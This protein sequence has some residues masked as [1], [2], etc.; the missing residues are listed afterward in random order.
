MFALFVGAYF[1]SAQVVFDPATYSGTIGTNMKIVTVGSDSYLQVVLDGYSDINLDP[2]AII[3]GETVKTS[4]KYASGIADGAIDTCAVFFKISNASID[5][6][7]NSS[8]GN[9]SA[10]FKEYSKAIEKQGVVEKLTIAAQVNKGSWPSIKG[11]TLWIGKVTVEPYNQPIEHKFITLET[12]GTQARDTDNT[13]KQ[14]TGWRNTPGLDTATAFHYDWTECTF[15]N[16]NGII[17][18]GSDSSIRINSYGVSSKPSDWPNP[19]GGMQLLMTPTASYMGSWDT[20][21]FS[22]IDVKGYNVENIA[23]GFAKRGNGFKSLDTAGINIEYKIDGGTWEQ[24]DTTVLPHGLVAD[25]WE[26]VKIPL[27]VTGDKI[28]LRIASF[29]NQAFID[30]IAVIGTRL[31]DEPLAIENIVVGKVDSAGDFTGSVQLEWDNDSIYVI[32]NI[33]DDSIVPG[34]PEYQVDNIEVYFDMDNSKNIHWPRNGGWM[35]SDPT[36]DTNDYQFRL[37]PDSAFAK[38]NSKFKGARQVYTKTADGYQFELNIALDSL[39]N[40]FKP[41]PYQRI[42]FDVLVSDNDAVASDA[43]RNQI[44]LVSPTDKPF[45]DPSLWG[46]LEFVEGG[47][48]NLLIDNQAPTTAPV[49]TASLATEFDSTINLSWTAATDNIAILK[50]IVKSNGKDTVTVYPSAAGAAVTS[51]LSDQNPGIYIISVTAVDNSGL[52]ITSLA[53]TIEVKT[54]PV[55]PISVDVIS[56]TSFEMYPNPVID[57]LNIK[58]ASIISKV[59]IS[60]I[61]GSVVETI[62]CNTEAVELNTSKLAKGLYFV[63]VIDIEGNKMT[64][65]LIKK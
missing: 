29:I 2:I 5:I 17:T 18:A 20:L 1:C 51:K 38:Y 46:T 14:A 64:N 23:F 27:N 7:A 24:A 56:A 25:E 21:V 19:S 40:G 28:A 62:I 6:S 39:L 31:P 48:F 49:L 35:A 42:G 12:F 9:A 47:G 37:V 54:P 50:Y 16:T 22:D 60:N 4:I 3:E 34:T 52:T 44:T 15:T 26:Y 30:D 41:V 65:R 45:N 63:T 32:F 57:V 36:F 10:T 33:V 43:N 58:N 13:R 59:E 53:D 8:A 61:N 11:D 55:G